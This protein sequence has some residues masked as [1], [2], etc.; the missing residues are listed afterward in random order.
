MKA[1][2]IKKAL[3]LLLCLAL[4]TAATAQSDVPSVLDRVQ[5]VDDPELSEL[6]RVAIENQS[7]LNRLG[8]TETM[9]LIRKVT[10]SYTQ[11]KL[12]DH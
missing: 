9:E 3:C 7:K 10:L 8:Q 1:K 5:N 12:F 11:I 6:I 4:A 2:W